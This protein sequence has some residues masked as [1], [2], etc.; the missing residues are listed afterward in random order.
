MAVAV[1]VAVA[2][3]VVVAAT[4]C[5][6]VPVAAA[7]ASPAPAVRP[8][9]NY[10]WDRISTYAFPGHV[11][12]ADFTDDQVAHYAKFSLLLFWGVNLRPDPTV[13]P[14]W[15][16]PDQEL[17][18]LRQAAAIKAINPDILLF[19]YITGFMA[20]TWF[21]AQVRPLVLGLGSSR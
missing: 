15:W 4:P 21:K 16:V 2:V 10:S 9:F 5:L 8:T 19:P 17:Q 6:Q 13:G 20:Q 1:V 3:A 18:A 12:G 11:V 14:G 7:A